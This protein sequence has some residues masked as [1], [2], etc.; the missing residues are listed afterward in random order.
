MPPVHALPKLAELVQLV[1]VRCRQVRCF[2]PI[3]VSSIQHRREMATVKRS[4]G[5]PPGPDSAAAGPRLPPRPAF[6]V[7][8]SP[9]AGQ[10]GQRLSGP[11]IGGPLAT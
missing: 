1:R 10:A 4:P 6:P 8:P 7:P 9:R 2:A 11:V 5:N 3:A